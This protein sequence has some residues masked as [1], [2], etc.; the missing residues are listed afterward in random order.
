M[1]I[2]QR[3]Q[4]FFK[5]G[6]VNQQSYI[7]DQADNIYDEAPQVD[8]DNETENV[9]SFSEPQCYHRQEKD[10]DNDTYNHLHQRPLQMSD[11]T[12]GVSTSILIPLS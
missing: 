2:Y 6:G 3:V 8:Q 12:Y 9:Y 5:A 1:F 11:D 7:H 10:S 4:Y